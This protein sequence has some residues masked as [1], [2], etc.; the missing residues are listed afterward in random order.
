M[1]NSASRGGS[2]EGKFCAIRNELQDSDA[3]MCL[4]GKE[5]ETLTDVIREWG[6]VGGVPKEKRRT[7][8]EYLPE[9]CRFPPR[10]VK[11]A[12]KVFQ[13]VGIIQCIFRGGTHNRASKYV[14]S[15]KWK[16]YDVS[17]DPES[18]RIQRRRVSDTRHR[19]SRAKAHKQ[20]L[21]RLRRRQEGEW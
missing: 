10:Q 21:V 2:I 9:Y 14:M 15:D 19:I 4:T 18:T 17:E 20:A 6:T 11:D 7:V 1:S 3:Y 5:V 16:K 8:F 12:L 13:Q